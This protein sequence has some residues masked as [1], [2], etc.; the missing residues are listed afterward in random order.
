MEINTLSLAA[1][2]T[3]LHIYIHF[4]CRCLQQFYPALYWITAGAMHPS[5]LRVCVCRCMYTTVCIFVYT[6]IY[7]ML[8][9]ADL[10]VCM[11]VWDRGRFV[12]IAA[13]TMEPWWTLAFEHDETIDRNDINLRSTAMAILFTIPPKIIRLTLAGRDESNIYKKPWIL[14]NVQQHFLNWIQTQTQ[15]YAVLQVHVVYVIAYKSIK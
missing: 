14:T 9:R 3:T 2:I 1:T 12:C 10:Y 4:M 15:A 11:S 7:F 5:I 13:A 6:H 8:S